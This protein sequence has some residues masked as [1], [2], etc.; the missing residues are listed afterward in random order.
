MWLIFGVV[1][2]IV[3]CIVVLLMLK[4]AHLYEH[5]NQDSDNKDDK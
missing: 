1:G 4:G 2:Y 3:A 5:D